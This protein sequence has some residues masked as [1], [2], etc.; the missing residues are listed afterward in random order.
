MTSRI[1]PLFGASAAGK[2]LDG[3]KTAIAAALIAAGLWLVAFG[4]AWAP[5]AFELLP[6]SELGAWPELFVPFL[7]MPLIG[8]GALL[9]IRGKTERKEQ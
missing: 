5:G 8:L 6:A 9:F 7:P 2:M 3:A 1:G 4:N